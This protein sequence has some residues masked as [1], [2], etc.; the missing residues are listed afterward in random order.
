GSGVPG[1]GGVRQSANAH[2]SRG[3]VTELRLTPSAVSDACIVNVAD[4]RSS[5]AGG[6]AGGGLPIELRR[7]P[8]VF[9]PAGTLLKRAITGAVIA[10]PYAC[11]AHR[12]GV[13][14]F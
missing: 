5:V 14:L 6:Y 7:I 8:T 4:D 2:W 9:V 12:W 1:N 10:D 13:V 11:L 3:I